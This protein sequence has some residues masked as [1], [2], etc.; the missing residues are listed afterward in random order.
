MKKNV[1]L[2]I[3]Y[4]ICTFIFLA[5]G[6]GSSTQNTGSEISTSNTIRNI[7]ITGVAHNKSGSPF[8]KNTLVLAVDINGNIA[9]GKVVDNL[10]RYEVT[11]T[12]EANTSKKNKGLGGNII[13]RVG[14]FNDTDF[15]TIV[16]P[17]NKNSDQ[18]TINVNSI[19][20]EASKVLLA[21]IDLDSLFILVKTA[22]AN[23]A[24]GK[25][26]VLNSND[27]DNLAIK[28][29]EI[30]KEELI[31]TIKIIT[32]EIFGIDIVKVDFL[33]SPITNSSAEMLS[34]ASTEIS[35]S[36]TFTIDT[37][38]DGNGVISPSVTV[39]KGENK[40]IT[41]T[42]N[43]GFEV[44]TLIVDGQSVVL[45][46]NYTFIN[47]T[48]NHT[49]S[50]T[51]KRKNY[52]IT[53]LAGNGGIISSSSI[54][55]YGS[56]ITISI[57]PSIGYELD[58]LMVDS[59]VV[60][61]SS[62]FTISNVN[63]NHS[64]SAT[65][66]IKTYLITTSSGLNGNISSSVTVN[67]GSKASI[68]ITPDI[69]FEIESL[70]VDNVIVTPV[71]N[72]VFS[73]VREDHSVS[74]TFKSVT[75]LI[76]TSSNGN[77]SISSNIL[78]NSGSNSTIII[79]PN[80][81]YGVSSIIVDGVSVPI[82]LSYTFNNVKANHTIS[83]SF[84]A[85]YSVISSAG[86][87]GSISA[88]ATVNSGSNLTF[89]I[90]PAENYII[91][92]L[93]VDGVEVSSSL[94][95]TFNNITSNHTINV[96]FKIKTYQITSS[97]DLNGTISANVIVSHGEGITFIMTPNSNYEINELKVDGVVVAS[98]LSYT[99]TNVV[100]PHSID[101]T[102][103][104]KSFIISTSSGA[105]GTISSSSSVSY[106]SNITINISPN[107]NFV[108][109]KLEV[110]GISVE[111][112]LSY[113]FNN[114]TENHSVSVTFAEVFSITSSFGS[115]GVISPNGSVIALEGFEKS[116]AI[117]PNPG[118]VVDVLTIDNVV[119]P[120]QYYFKFS[121]INASHSIHATFKLSDVM[122]IGQ[123]LPLDK[124]I[125]KVVAWG[126]RTGAVLSDSSV[127]VWGADFAR[128][129]F[130]P[131]NVTGVTD[132]ALGFSN[133]YA[134]K[135]D[136]TVSS[137]YVGQYI[138]T[139]S[140]GARITAIAAGYRHTIV[141]KEDSSVFV[142]GE[143]NENQLSI[144]ANLTEVIAIA[145]GGYHSVALK[146]DGTVVS[147]GKNTNGQTSIPITATNII[148]ISAGD[149]HTVALKSDGSVIA[150]GD[151]SF[152]QSST[153]VNA[154]NVIAIAAGGNHTVALKS[155]GSIVS[156]GNNSN[157]QIT[158][159]ANTTNVIAIAAGYAHTVALL[160][161]KKLVMWGNNNYNQITDP[162]NLKSCIAISGSLDNKLALKSDGTLIAWGNNTY[163]QTTIPANA[164]G[165]IAIATKGLHSLAL[166]NDGT[167]IAWGNNSKGQTNIP[168]NTAGVIAIAAGARHSL[169]LKSNGTIIAW[170]ENLHGETTI[171]VNAINVVAIAS[172]DFHSVALKSDGT[173]V[174]WGMNTSGQTTIPANATGIIAIASGGSHNLA[175]KNDGTVIAW[176]DNQ[177]LQT[178]VPSSA[179]GVVSIDAGSSHSVALKS[180]GSVI[181]WGF[182]KYFQNKIPLNLP[183]VSRISASGN[184]SYF[185]F[186]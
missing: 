110:D 97:S 107:P 135:N 95:Y 31:S 112:T 76:S 63:S 151:N 144:P 72:Y 20:S 176:G 27:Q 19:V 138:S 126:D 145:A 28:N 150:W 61:S 6:G 133:T 40:I 26:P 129:T 154:I 147:W 162:V 48:A 113:S 177:A 169:A 39:N 74:A 22:I 35:N 163:G 52:T 173:L 179:I 122:A 181:A 1:G 65:F 178:N 183:A 59:V 141:L 127:I 143:N 15:L 78:V 33:E 115:N 137:W 29:I 130:V 124:E 51:F 30:S 111:S 87:N 159:P 34:Y 98:T 23:V 125:V 13:I 136:G 75:Y 146:K 64:I 114:V 7:N 91:D 140:F 58:V 94:I 84:V 83:V 186:Q 55:S 184:V 5:C 92:L 56:S 166:K 148:A 4:F 85:G 134:L 132:L 90:T 104:L 77:G 82:S 101:V 158:I 161:D 185:F 139:P 131:D 9:Q 182:D 121:S 44:S 164:T 24:D 16:V 18:I 21:G 57:T 38:S 120:S 96:T 157:G 73:D 152:G 2:K 46:D 168:A 8:E 180:D 103:K 49:I 105:N 155:D 32:D 67:H 175:L 17:E 171:P 118:Y 62:S 153:P 41:L 167:I 12:G 170:G 172:G 50:V 45:S 53:T 123:G 10:G 36:S 174:A 66:K 108:I 109:A 54:V 100:M 37:F 60:N 14:D 102:Y 3:I 93:T 43:E 116:F 142:W 25:S 119:V 70:R 80:I 99:F 88:G 89:T 156:W 165:I 149:S 47:V 42:P 69:G 117:I 79:T 86:I 106:G 160:S 11:L 68:T 71:L 81:G 128:Q